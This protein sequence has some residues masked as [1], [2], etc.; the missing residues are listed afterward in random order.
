MNNT[1]IEMIR[2]LLDIIEDKNNKIDCLKVG[3]K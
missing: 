1:D 3:L 2:D